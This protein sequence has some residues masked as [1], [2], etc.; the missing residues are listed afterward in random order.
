MACWARVFALT[1][2]F[3][4]ASEA[5]KSLTCSID[6][7]IDRRGQRSHQH[8]SRGRSVMTPENTSLITASVSTCASIAFGHCGCDGSCTSGE[9]MSGETV[10]EIS[11]GVVDCALTPVRKDRWR[12]QHERQD[13]ADP[14]T[15]LAPS[16]RALIQTCVAGL[17]DS[18]ELAGLNR[19]GSAPLPTWLTEGLALRSSYSAWLI[20]PESSKP[21]AWEIWSEADADA[22]NL[23]GHLPDVRVLARNG[24]PAFAIEPRP[25]HVRVQRGRRTRL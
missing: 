3:S 6:H 5:M 14:C 10:S 15:D 4:K 23:T 7:G 13:Q 22:V 20:A 11:L 2:R 25:S 24:T 8:C 12:R 1:H 21:L 17:R 19:D 16:W 9:S 18:A